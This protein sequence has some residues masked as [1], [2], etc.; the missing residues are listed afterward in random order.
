MKKNRL[1]LIDMD[2]TLVNTDLVNFKAYRHAIS[3]NS[4]ILLSLDDFNS[5]CKSKHYSEFLPK[6]GINDT[7]LIS[8]IHNLKKKLYS[9][10]LSES[11][12]N[13]SLVKIINALK[14]THHIGL[15]TTA[16]KKNCVELLKHHS[17]HD[18]FELIITGD[19]VK[20]SKPDPESYNM[21]ISYFNIDHKNI[22]AFEDSDIGIAAAR[23]SGISTIYIVDRF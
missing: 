10:F 12:V 11:N 19:D 9:Q 15:V 8:E 5:I 23:K 2:G 4:N 22:I 20:N 6:I 7:A 17:L 18:K 13:I 3:K 14:E 21:A 16:S 1:L